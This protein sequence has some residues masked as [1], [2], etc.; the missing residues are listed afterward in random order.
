MSEKA[1]S[2]GSY[3]FPFREVLEP[4]A[5][6]VQPTPA[7]MRRAQYVIGALGELGLGSQLLDIYEW[8]QNQNMP[9]KERMEYH[10]K[11]NAYFRRYCPHIQK[12][13]TNMEIHWQMQ[14][15]MEP[16]R[17]RFSKRDMQ[18]VRLVY[19]DWKA[20]PEET[21][22]QKRMKTW[23]E[24]GLFMVMSSRYYMA[25][26]PQPEPHPPYCVGRMAR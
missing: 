11:W 16:Y 20:M 1:L 19:E 12:D 23:T 5:Q 14:N 13:T 10:K 21:L 22:A 9:L 8:L 24:R 7:Q 2:F 15:L 26:L 18:A 17:P 6:A 3:I 25:S 4:M